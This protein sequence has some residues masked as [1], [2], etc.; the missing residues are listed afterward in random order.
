M[1]EVEITLNKWGMGERSPLGR[2]EIANDL[3]G[4]DT[5]GNYH[6]DLYDKG[7][8]LHKSGRITGFPRNRRS[9]MHLVRLVL[10]DA[11]KDVQS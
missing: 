6:Y 7:G 2:I 8:S 1:I 3:S 4:T 11:H 9:A 5:K 10:E